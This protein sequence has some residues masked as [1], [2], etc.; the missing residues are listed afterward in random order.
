MSSDP[1]TIASLVDR[2]SKAG[3]IERAPDPEDRRAYR[4]KI[5][6]TG[7]KRYTEARRVAVALQ[8]TVLENVP[9][10]DREAFLSQL[11]AVADACLSAAE[12]SP[13]S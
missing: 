13:R 8:E 5:N 2:M 4:L 3:L 10:A 9:P 1:N 12:N 7:R 11:N 6:A